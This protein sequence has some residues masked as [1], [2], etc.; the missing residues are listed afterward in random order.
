MSLA[1]V[2]TE[3]RRWRNRNFP[4]H[5]PEDAIFGMME[6]MGEL[7]HAFLKRKQGIRGT[8]QEHSL[9]IEDALCDW[10]IYACGLADHEG[11]DLEPALAATWQRVGSRDWQKNKTDGT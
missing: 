1:Q 4:G 11:I 9:A 5:T 3:S 8:A 7:V 2:Q 10:I 6:E